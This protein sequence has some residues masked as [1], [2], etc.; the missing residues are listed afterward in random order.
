M[1]F[2]DEDSV[3]SEIRYITIE[4]MKIAAQKGITFE[5]VAR[6]F[7][8]NAIFLKRLIEIT[9]STDQMSRVILSKINMEDLQKEHGSEQERL[10]FQ[11]EIRD[12]RDRN[13]SKKKR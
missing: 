11:K 12:T 7:L 8:K 10:K 3:N 5:E 2:D 1:G 9:E 4:L 6:E 13:I